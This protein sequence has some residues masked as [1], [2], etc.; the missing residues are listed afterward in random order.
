MCG[1]DRQEVRFHSCGMKK[2]A[3]FCP[4]LAGTLGHPAW[5]V[6]IVLLHVAVSGVGRRYG[7][8]RGSGREGEAG[9]G[10][11]LLVPETGVLQR[12]LAH[13]PRLQVG[14]RVISQ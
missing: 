7:D 11:S 1:P 4:R 10:V 12:R 13:S 5:N 6:R 8:R 9:V 2:D 3:R 14:E